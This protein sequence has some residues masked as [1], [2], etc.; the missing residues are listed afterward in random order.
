MSEITQKTHVLP[1]KFLSQSQKRHNLTQKMSKIAKK[2]SFC[3]DGEPN[4]CYIG[5]HALYFH[6][7]ILSKVFR[8][9]EFFSDH[10]VAPWPQKRHDKNETVKNSPEK[11][12]SV[13][14]LIGN[15]T[16]VTLLANSFYF[17]PS[18]MFR[19]HEE[20]SVPLSCCLTTK[21]A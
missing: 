7:M 1:H 10:K 13:L 17:H 12:L 19:D 15:L 18:K 11:L 5:N 21:A 16:A 14:M 4:R 8:A 9:Q 3:S 20:N 6:Y 2:S